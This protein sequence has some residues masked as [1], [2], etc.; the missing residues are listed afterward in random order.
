M[1]HKSGFVNLVGKPNAGKSTLMNRFVGE[2]LS[3]ITP[4]AQTT[5]HRIIGIV[6]DEDFQVVFSDTP[7]IIDPKYALQ[8]S[9]MSFVKEAFQDADILLL[10]LDSTEKE[11]DLLGFEKGLGKEGEIPIYVVLNK[12]DLIDQERLE[13][14]MD[15]VHKKFP[16]AR[17]FPISALHEFGVEGLRKQLISDL[18]EGPPYFD[19]DAL[20]DKPVRFFVSEIIREQIL[21]HYDKEIPYAVQIEVE[22]FKD[23][24][25]LIRISAIIFVERKSQKGILIGH[26]GKMLKLVG[27]EARKK[28]EEFLGKKVFLELFVKIDADWRRKENR[29]KAYGYKG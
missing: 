22:S 2:R 29:L 7:G 17:I 5:R 19:K 13:K 8:S 21:Q 10:I 4:K 1:T 9:M 20:T 3:I 25:Q 15:E 12:I 23:T 24:G 27:T 14:L 28:L 6:N 26:K 11:L 16:N 18:P